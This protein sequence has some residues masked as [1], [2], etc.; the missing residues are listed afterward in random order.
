MQR[1]AGRSDVQV[2]MAKTL[3]SQPRAALARRG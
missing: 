2:M 3:Y 1:T